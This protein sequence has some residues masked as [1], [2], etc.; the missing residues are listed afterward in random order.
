M[1]RGSA[2]LPHGQ[3]S[4]HAASEY[5]AVSSPTLLCGQTA[6]SAF[7]D[8]S[9]QALPSDAK[10]GQQ[11]ARAEPGLD[12]EPATAA[13]ERP[14]YNLLG[15]GFSSPKFAGSR[16]ETRRWRARVGRG[17][18]RRPGQRRQAA[19]QRRRHRRGP[20]RRQ[21][22]GRHGGQRAARALR[23]PPR[24][25]RRARSGRQSGRRGRREHRQ[26][27]RCRCPQGVRA[28]GRR[29]RGRAARRRR[30]LRAAAVRRH[31]LFGHQP[32][33]ARQALDGL[34]AARQLT[35]GPQ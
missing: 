24:A 7:R 26:R 19:P 10:V 27:H 9:K 33:P 13:R 16:Y 11:A 4:E 22:Q 15:S 25:C 20:A 18:G 5:A 17:D 29:R 12:R 21:R 1:W 30:E 32:R 3:W 14:V 2:A 35:L 8:A 28:C 34:A 6:H 23:R 31:A